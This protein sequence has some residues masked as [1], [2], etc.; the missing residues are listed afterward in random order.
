MRWSSAASAASIWGSG[1][2]VG[3]EVGVLVGSVVGVLVGSEV[4]VLVGSAVAV[5]VR[6]GARLAAGREAAALA[7]A[8]ASLGAA[9]PAVWLGVA[10]TIGLVQAAPKT[11][12]SVSAD[13]SGRQ[14]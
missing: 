5:A 6:V 10:G 8:R 9:E 4:G 14:R 13:H 11:R 1:V 7:S 3:S 12:H 2:G